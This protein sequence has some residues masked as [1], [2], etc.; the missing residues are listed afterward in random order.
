MQDV[1]KGYVHSI[2]VFSGFLSFLKNVIKIRNNDPVFT[3]MSM[4]SYFTQTEKH[5]LQ[6]ACRIADLPITKYVEEHVAIAYAYQWMTGPEQMFL[7]TEKKPLNVLF[8]DI[9]YS[10]TNIF[11]VS[12]Q[13]LQA[14]ILSVN[15]NRHLGIRDI[16]NAL[17]EHMQSSF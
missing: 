7:R 1:K 12:F 17:L 8:I 6:E 9:G 10:K 15:C 14:N 13:S 3:V 5:N 2:Q 11:L 4:P 16:D